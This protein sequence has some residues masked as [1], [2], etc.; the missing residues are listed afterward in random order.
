[1]IPVYKPYLPKH[2][3]RYAHDALGSGWLSRGKYNALA[4]E[5]LQE[6]LRVK[7]VLLTSN[8]TTAG[9]LVAIALKDC[10]GYNE[11]IMPNNVYVAAWNVYKYENIKINIVDAN[12][13]TWNFDYKLLDKA[14]RKNTDCAVGV[15]HNLG[16]IVN[17]PNLKQQYPNT[18]FVE[19]ACEGFLGEYSGKPVGSESLSFV[20]F[21]GNKNITSGEGGAV[22]INDT[23]IYEYLNCKHGQGQHF[24]DERFVHRML[25]YNYRMTNVQAALLCGQL[26]C[27]DQIKEN[28]KRVFD[29]YYKHLG[30]EFVLQETD[31][32]TVSAN[33]M[34]GI[35][36]SGSN[37]KNAESLFSSRGIEIRPM[38]CDVGLHGHFGGISTFNN[39]YLLRRECIVLPSYPELTE[40]EIKYIVKTL[41]EYK[42]NL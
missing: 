20:S 11:I 18:M 41:K 5:K 22:L 38:F 29:T 4:S 26:E 16:N 13:K 14:I 21:F 23:D 12:I 15:V 39:A 6:I 9:H 2:I 7:H 25:G 31:P 42:E 19:D 32:N 33:W 28:K 3:L 40:D 35:R 8:G 10:F 30:S 36:V 1:M 27:L 24:D 37:Y 34:L 17:V